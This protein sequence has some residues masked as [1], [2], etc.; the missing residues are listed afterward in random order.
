MYNP[1][2][3]TEERTLIPLSARHVILLHVLLKKFLSGAW[4]YS[5]MAMNDNEI[6]T[7]YASCLPDSVKCTHTTPPLF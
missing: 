7:I 6:V 5:D 3:P 1:P 4:T 2:P